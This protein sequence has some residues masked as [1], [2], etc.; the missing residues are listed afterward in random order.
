MTQFLLVYRRSTGEL[1]DW[2]DLGEDRSAATTVRT[3][4]EKLEKDDPDVEVIVLSATDR[5]AVM[6]TH[7]RYFTRERARGPAE[8]APQT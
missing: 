4:R 5:E 6:K 7:A 8:N 3:E 2:K 1:I